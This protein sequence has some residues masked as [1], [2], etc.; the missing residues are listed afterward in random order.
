MNMTLPQVVCSATDTW[1]QCAEAVPVREKC[2]EL[3]FYCEKYGYIPWFNDMRDTT[4][5][6]TEAS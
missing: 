1:N 4:R 5:L 6:S 3:C 2:T